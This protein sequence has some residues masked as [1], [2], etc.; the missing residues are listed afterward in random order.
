MINLIGDAIAFPTPTS[1]IAHHVECVTLL[2]ESWE[3]EERSSNSVPR[4]RTLVRRM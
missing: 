3:D 1:A 4:M 2:D